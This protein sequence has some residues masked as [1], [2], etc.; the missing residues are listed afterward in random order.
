MLFRSRCR[1][2]SG[3]VNDLHSALARVKGK[4]NVVRGDN[5]GEVRRYR[6]VDERCG[7]AVGYVRP[8]CDQRPELIVVTESRHEL[9]EGDRADG[10]PGV[11]DGERT[12]GNGLS[13]TEVKE[14]QARATGCRDVVDEAPVGG[15][16]NRGPR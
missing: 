9:R 8:R 14:A 15:E 4:D 1:R 7:R 16:G 10:I 2:V 5:S 13:P 6:K 11:G 3:E 12:S